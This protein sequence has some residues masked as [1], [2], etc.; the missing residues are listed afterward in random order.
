MRETDTRT[1]ASA[2]DVL[3]NEIQSGDGVANLACR[4]A[5]QRLRELQGERDN[6]LAAMRL[7]WG[8]GFAK[9]PVPVEECNE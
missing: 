2:M 9:V 3:A 6:L 5:A 4:E 8:N 7:V 1:L